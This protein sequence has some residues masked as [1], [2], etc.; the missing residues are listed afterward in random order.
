MGLVMKKENPELFESEWAI[1]QKIRELE[2]C[3]APKVQE[4]LQGEKRWAYPTVKT[5]MDKMVKK[6]LL[7]TEKIR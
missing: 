3:V 6:G 4:A 5:M 2:P 7:K 1:L